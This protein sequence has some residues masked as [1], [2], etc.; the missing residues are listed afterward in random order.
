M[1]DSP[2]T[3][4]VACFHKM[5]CCV[6]DK[7]TFSAHNSELLGTFLVSTIGFMAQIEVEQYI[8]L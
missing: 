8:T 6:N 1:L 3:R 4:C 5:H 7:T 2:N